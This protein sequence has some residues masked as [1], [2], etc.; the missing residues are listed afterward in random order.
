MCLPALAVAVTP[1]DSAAGNLVTYI[2]GYGVL[3]IVAVAFAFRFIVPARS[4]DKERDQARA[5]LI[6]ENRRLLARAEKAETQLAESQRAAQEQFIPLLGSFTA[7]TQ[8]LIPLLQAQVRYREA[9][10]ERNP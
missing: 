8:S 6:E 7:A 4:A 2:L 5:D 1:A 9:G 3:G 10:H